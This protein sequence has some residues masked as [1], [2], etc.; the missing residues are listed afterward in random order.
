MQKENSK[1]KYGIEAKK[2]I[3]NI[4]TGF[5]FEDDLIKSILET[6][7]FN[8]TKVEVQNYSTEPLKEPD[9]K[10]DFHQCYIAENNLIALGTKIL[11]KKLIKKCNGYSLSIPSK[12][13]PYGSHAVAM[14]ID[15]ENKKISYHDSHGEDMPKPIKDYLSIL[16]PKYEM[17]IDR[18]K[19][20]EDVKSFV[21]GSDENDNSCAC[22]TLYNLRDMWYKR[23]GREDEVCQFK[24]ME[25]RNDAW[26]K[27]KVIE[28]E[29]IFEEPAKPKF[30]FG[31]IKKSLPEPW[32]EEKK[33]WGEK[34]QQELQNYRL[35]NEPDYQDRL[36]NA[37]NITRN[38]HQ[39]LLNKLINQV[40][41][42][43]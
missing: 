26:S 24:S 28:V 4:N 27:I 37:I 30:K 23:S 2:A 22:L 35:E 1:Y 25:A 29:P 39:A 18:T 7:G 16:L 17:F 6:Q 12:Q 13:V 5:G 43:I 20:Q 33:A 32:S 9:G 42:R 11:E 36:K 19:L 21:P 14:M 10:N 31:V 8:C 34:K 15:D 41:S 40:N 38:N 3:L